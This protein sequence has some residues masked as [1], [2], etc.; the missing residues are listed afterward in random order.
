MK[1]VVKLFLVASCALA[2]APLAW[3]GVSSFKRPAELAQIPPSLLPSSFTVQN[4]TELFLRRPFAAYY[5]NSL[6]I[7]ALAALCA[8]R[9]RSHRCTRSETLAVHISFAGDGF[10][11]NCA[12]IL[13][14][15]VRQ[16]A[17]STSRTIIPY[18]APLPLP[19]GC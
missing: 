18:A 7:S 2:A 14:N 4:Y 10:F 17:L 12:G 6:V 11:P 13:T 19:S 5:L 15:F 9:R 3:Y 1:W 16:P 8:S